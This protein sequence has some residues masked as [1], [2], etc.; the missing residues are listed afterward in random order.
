MKQ[1]YEMK[2]GIFG[3]VPILGGVRLPA[4]YL[5]DYIDTDTSL[6]TFFESYS[7]DP[8]YVEAFLLHPL[9]LSVRKN[10]EKSLI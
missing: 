4:F 10:Y 5:V 2:E 7:L 6:D 3:G 1:P 9:P 8:E